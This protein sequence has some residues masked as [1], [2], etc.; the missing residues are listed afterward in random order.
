MLDKLIKWFKKPKYSEWCILATYSQ[1]CHGYCVFFRKNYK[2]GILYFKTKKIG[3]Y[4]YDGLGYKD[5]NIGQKWK[6]MEL[7]NY[8][9]K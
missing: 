6:D 8:D 2:N 9:T 5:N 1:N 3:E 7:Q 4:C